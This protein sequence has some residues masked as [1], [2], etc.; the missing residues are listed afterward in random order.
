MSDP[1]AIITSYPPAPLEPPP[2]VPEPPRPG[3][4]TTNEHFDPNTDREIDLEWDYDRPLEWISEWAVDSATDAVTALGLAEILGRYLEP[5]DP[6][7]PVV[8]IPDL[9][10]ITERIEQGAETAHRAA[11]RARL[12]AESPDFDPV[13]DLEAFERAT[14]EC[15]AATS[16]VHA[17]TIALA[18]VLLGVTSQWPASDAI[19][20]TEHAVAV[21]LSE[22]AGDKR[23]GDGEPTLVSRTRAELVTEISGV[24][25]RILSEPAYHWE[26]SFV[27]LRVS[28]NRSL[29]FKG[30]AAGILVAFQAEDLELDAGT[31]AVLEHIGWPPGSWEEPSDPNRAL[32]LF[33]YVRLV[34][35][36]YVAEIAGLI[37]DTLFDVLG[38]TGPADLVVR[39]CIDDSGPDAVLRLI[40]RGGSAQDSPDES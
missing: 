38:V 7:A 29:Y 3:G 11:D 24:I 28:P 34:D 33:A 14:G 21:T 10:P 27:N 17:D 32:G 30:S 18:T 35:E 13:A 39:S 15:G 16:A 2:G 36:F 20:F 31:A 4:T 5:S 23:V 37:V 6:E 26:P 22:L 40:A 19:H 1:P 25:C 12:I 8:A 9:G